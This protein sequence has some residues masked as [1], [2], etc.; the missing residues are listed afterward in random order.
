M[1][2]QVFK[3][4]DPAYAHRCLRAAE[5]QF[6]LADTSPS[7][8]LT[9][10]IPFDFYPETEWR[11]DLELGAAELAL[12]LQDGRA[13][14]NLPH[15]DP[16][17]YL[18]RA[19]H[20]ARAYIDGPGDAADTLNLYDVSALAHSEL[21]HAI[22][23]AGDP[24]GLE[25]SRTDLLDD[26][27][28]A[29]DRAVAQ[30]NGDAFGFGFPWNV[31]DT[32]SHGAG[33]SVQAS[34]YDQLSGSD[35]YAAWSSRWLGNVLG[36]NA[37]G[38][39]FIV[40]DGTLWPHCLQHQVANIVGSLDGSGPVLAGAAVEGPN[41]YAA[42]G[43]VDGMRACPADGKNPY[44]VFNGRA[45]FRDDTETYDNTEPAIDLT[46]TSPLAFALQALGAY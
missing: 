1:C 6:D 21:S 3:A 39:S 44:A 4:S 46:A 13:P 19:A 16:A 12:A 9:T 20:W 17:Y 27:G 7:G 10:V 30:S 2:Y 40:G 31:W 22:A 35:R 28:L 32:T 41:G 36:A 38:L 33:L 18:Q 43:T 42:H 25:V 15:T 26:I 45:I 37:W 29:L 34:L 24:A 14:G 23:A 8:D 5:H 11:D